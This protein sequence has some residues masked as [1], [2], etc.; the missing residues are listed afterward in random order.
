[1]LELG[2]VLLIIGALVAIAAYAANGPALI[3]R[4]GVGAAVFGV[5]LV[6]VALLVPS[7]HGVDYDALTPLH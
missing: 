2:V 1:M 7:L 5:I 4:L 3:Y 6:L